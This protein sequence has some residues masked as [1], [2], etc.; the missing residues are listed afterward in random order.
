MKLLHLTL[1][2]LITLSGYTQREKPLSVRFTGQFDFSVKGMSSNDAG[3]GVQTGVS[4]LAKKPVQL[5]AEA[6]SHWYM[7]DQQYVTDTEGHELPNG[8]LHTLQAGPQV[9]LSPSL[10]LCATY[11]L[12]WHRQHERDY[13][14][15]DG[16][17]IGLTGYFGNG[18]N[19]VTQLSWMQVPRPEA[20]IQHFGIG[21]G[22]RL[23]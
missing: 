8:S 7:G 13:T 4:F 17:R 20:P 12:A 9:F 16:Y 11:G 18:N 22:Y 3:M 21:V 15:D 14:L 6:G 1:A 23:L 2:L 19:F 5:L 10:S